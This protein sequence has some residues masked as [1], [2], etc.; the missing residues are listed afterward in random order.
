V[1]EKNR[2]QLFAK[3]NS[4]LNQFSNV[5][6]YRDGEPFKFTAFLLYILFLLFLSLANSFS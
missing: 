6:D 1:E 5:N 3:L 4:G 2:L